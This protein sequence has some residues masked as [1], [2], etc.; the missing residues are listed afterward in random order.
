[1]GR[2]RPAGSGTEEV[3]DRRDQ[4]RSL[5][6]DVADETGDRVKRERHGRRTAPAVREVFAGLLLAPW[7]AR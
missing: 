1:V 7:A 5:I 4:R 3:S 2:A 6:A